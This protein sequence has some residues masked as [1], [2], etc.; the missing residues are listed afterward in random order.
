MSR[1]DAPL[2]FVPQL[3][4]RVWGG[5]RLK[6]RVADPPPEPVGESW[7]LSDVDGSVSATP[8]GVPLRELLARH[9]DAIVGDGWDPAR[10]GR[11]PLLVKL[12]ETRQDLSVQVHP[13][14]ETAARCGLG[15]AGKT[16]A[17]YVLDAAPGARIWAGLE[18]GT[19]RGAFERALARGEVARVLHAIEPRAGDAIPVPGGTVHA[20]GAGLELVEIQQTSDVTFRLWDWGR[21]GLDGR[22][23]ELHVREALEVIRWDAPP[24]APAPARSVAQDGA[25]RRRLID[26]APF[27]VDELAE[28]DEGGAPLDTGGR[29]QIVIPVAGRVLVVTPGGRLE[30]T[31]PDLALVPAAAGRWRLHGSRDARVLLVQR[32]PA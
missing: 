23:R 5:E 31:A 15:P 11:F 10:P 29:F 4:P 1:P 13:D 9:G 17:W 2:A 7:E 8:D 28:F 3:K 16:E 27:V 12:L 21:V 14:D 19:D 32:P 22:P 25:A 20:L 6:A 26:G 30:R 24:P 18:P